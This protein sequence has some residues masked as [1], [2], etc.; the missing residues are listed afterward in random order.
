MKGLKKK[1][2]AVFCAAVIAMTATSCG[3]EIYSGSLQKSDN[4]SYTSFIN[5]DTSEKETT[6]VTDNSS[7]AEPQTSATEVTTPPDSP[8]EKEPSYKVSLLCVGDN[9]IHDNIYLE[10]E[11]KAGE[12]GKYNFDDAYKPIE[13]YIKGN[14]LAIVNQETIVTDTVAP[15]SFPTFASPKAV[16]DKVM[17]VTVRPV[18][19]QTKI[20]ESC[21]NVDGTINYTQL[22][23]HL[24][25]NAARSHLIASCIQ[26]EKGHSCLI[27]SDRIAQLED[28]QD[29][30]PEEMLAES[31]LITGKM[32]SKSGKAL[33]EQSIEKMR[34]GEL[35]YLFATYSL[36]KEGLDIPR[37]DR[38]FL[39]S[40]VKFS[41]VVIQSIG[42]IARTFEGKET[43]VCYDFVDVEIGFC[44]RAFKER[45]RHYRKEQAIIEKGFLEDEGQG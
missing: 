33:R 21:L 30:L 41:S 4:S 37:L 31:A 42:R 2:A 23:E 29:M 26:D 28:I 18:E 7:V 8:A 43:P 10:A 5:S 24:T 35:K 19:T 12:K 32:T 20:S 45:C 14:D 3:N 9:L 36:A 27:L 40:P 39:A 15:E 17:R 6:K 25:T 22:I 11:K 13:S 38:L 16:A 44:R 1:L 34:T